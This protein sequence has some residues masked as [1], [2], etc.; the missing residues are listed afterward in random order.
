[1]GYL[2]KMESGVFSLATAL[3]RDATAVLAGTVA[4]NAI[5]PVAIDAAREG[6]PPKCLR[7]PPRSRQESA[8]DQQGA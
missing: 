6:P 2:K 4:A 1:L 5:R 3:K 7:T 8:R